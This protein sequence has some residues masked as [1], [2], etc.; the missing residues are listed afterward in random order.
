MT[1]YEAIQQI[2]GPELQH[3]NAR[4]SSALKSDNALIQRIIDEYLISKGKQIRPIM[5]IL[6]ARLFGKVNQNVIAAAAAIEML[7][8]ASLIHD[9]VIDETKLRRGRNTINSTWDNHIAVLVGDFFISNALTQAI[10][11]SDVRIIESIAR[12]GTLLSVGEMDQ[13]YT[14]HCHRRD[15]EAYFQIINNKTASLFVGCVEM[16]GYAVGAPDVMLEQMRKFAQLVGLCF[17]IK[18][19]IFDYYSDTNIGKPTGNDLREGKVT[20]P[21]LY[22]LNKEQLNGRQEMISL[23]ERDNLSTDEIELLVSYAKDNG[24]IEYAY[25][26]MGRL[27]KEAREVLDNISDIYPVDQEA[28]SALHSIIDYIVERDK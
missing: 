17:Q 10:N 13:I 16:G 9:D 24:G 1:P 26:T 8:N 6:T 11:T 2:I 12:L 4:I 21:L 14:A 15:E 3:L 7:H 27:S 19:D 5:V 25:A 18:D 22:V 28:Y 23:I 20:L